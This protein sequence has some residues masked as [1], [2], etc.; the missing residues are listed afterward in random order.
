LEESLSVI[1][2]VRNAQD[3]IEGQIVELLEILPDLTS[4]FEIIVV[5][6]ASTDQTDDVV[7]EL[8]QR[9]P[10]IRVIRHGA[11][12]GTQAALQ[13]AMA[14]THA[15]IVFVHQANTRVS[16]ARLFRLWQMR[17]DDQLVIAQAMPEPK[18]IPSRVIDSLV[19]WGMK[20]TEMDESSAETGGIQMIR[21]KTP[22]DVA[23]Q[24]AS[25]EDDLG[26][27]ISR[28]DQPQPVAQTTISNTRPLH[29][30]LTRSP[31]SS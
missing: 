29:R 17:N 12:M 4:Q 28:T 15:D 16:Q 24:D 6:D 3:R 18:P 11:N 20:V 10:Q 1:L 22:E 2:P 19:K 14:M 27:P 25:N 23:D 13:D 31:R 9:Y 5:D 26:S 8:A 7:N 30:G 21:R